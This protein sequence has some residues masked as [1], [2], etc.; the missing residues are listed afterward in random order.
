MRC[1]RYVATF[2]VQAMVDAPVDVPMLE[3]GASTADGSS[4]K[5]D[6][7]TLH[8]VAK[9]YGAKL[10]PGSSTHQANHWHFSDRTSVKV[11]HPHQTLVNG[12][13]KRLAEAG[14]L[15]VSKKDA[16]ANKP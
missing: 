14:I 1:L 9:R 6:R 4:V 15:Q 8:S 12:M 7:A 11:D 16:L 2:N 13:A 10:A 3:P 5:C